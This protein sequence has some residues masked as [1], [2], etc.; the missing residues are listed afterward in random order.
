MGSVV[1]HM[2]KTILWNDRIPCFTV[3]VRVCHPGMISQ[4]AVTGWDSKPKDSVV[5]VDFP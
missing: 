1:P 2:M 3:P 4:V 5:G